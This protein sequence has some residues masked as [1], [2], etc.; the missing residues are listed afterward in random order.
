M[1]EFLH[2]NQ[3]DT[4]DLLVMIVSVRRRHES[5]LHH[6]TR[7]L[8]QQIGQINSR[9]N[10]NDDKINVDLVICNSDA[11]PHNHQDANDL[12]NFV[13]VITINKTKRSHKCCN[14]ETW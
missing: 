14:K 13:D 1:I 8:H 11:E 2:Y 3:Q 4:L 5:Y 9:R 6:T 7:L 12:S 10:K